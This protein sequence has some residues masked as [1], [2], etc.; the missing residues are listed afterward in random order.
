MTLTRKRNDPKTHVTII[1]D[2]YSEN[3]LDMTLWVYRWEK[4]DGSFTFGWEVSKEYEKTTLRENWSFSSSPTFGEAYAIALQEL[5]KRI[6]KA[7]IFGSTHIAGQVD[8]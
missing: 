2:A 8:F 1:E 3:Y 4:E 7:D 6:D 5:L